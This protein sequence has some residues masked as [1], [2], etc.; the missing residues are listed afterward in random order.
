MK[1]IVI[2]AA[3]GFIGTHLCHHFSK[4]HQVIGLVRSQPP[5]GKNIEY[6]TW[7]GKNLGDWQNSLN[8]AEV[9]INLA[10]KSVNCRHTPENKKG[11]LESRLESTK[12]LGQA[13]EQCK[14]KP[15]VW[16]NASGASIYLYQKGVANTEENSVYAQTFIAEVSKRWESALYEFQ[17]E[18]IRQVALR[19][20]VVLGMEGGAFPVINRLVKLGLGGKQGSGEQMMSWIHITDFVNAV[21][22]I[23]HSEISG[24]VNMGSPNPLSN[25][26][27]MSTLRK[28]NG[29]CIG[30]PTPEFMLRIGSR[31]IDTEPDLVLDDMYVKPKVLLKSGF[32]FE[33]PTLSEAVMNLIK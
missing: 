8:G 14:E 24:P 28:A 18:D 2:A 19:T 31:F 17:F 13:I 16:I 9:L 22:H 21:D 15:K 6:V 29:S 4:T 26:N 5:S 10:G 33:F 7:D 20:T 30:I 27:F 1:K 11:I 23:V 3:N 12:V 32:E 25:A